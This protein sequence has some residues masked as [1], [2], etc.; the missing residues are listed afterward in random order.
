[1]A[2]SDPELFKVI[3]EALKNHLEACTFLLGTKYAEVI[4]SEDRFHL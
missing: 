1:V 3:L 4:H 2:A